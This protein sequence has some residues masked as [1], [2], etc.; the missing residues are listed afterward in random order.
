[1]QHIN[2]HDG[3]VRVV[4]MGPEPVEEGGEQG[5]PESEI[6]KQGI[7]HLIKHIAVAMRRKIDPVVLAQLLAVNLGEYRSRP[8]PSREPS[9]GKAR[10]IKAGLNNT[11]GC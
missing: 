3:F 10:A 2:L 6:G 7:F 1:M 9:G 11:L 4:A 5:R 8:L